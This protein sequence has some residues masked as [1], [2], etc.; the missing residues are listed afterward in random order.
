MRPLLLL[1]VSPVI[2]KVFI[3]DITEN[4]KR[5]NLY[6]TICGLCIVF[7]MGLRS[8]FSGSTDTDSYC[9]LFER[10][11]K[12]G[13]G[14]LDFIERRRS[15]SGLLFSEI[16]YSIYVWL[17]ANIFESSQWL[18]IIT[19]IIMTVC[20][21][22][23]I[24]KHSED[25]VVSLVMFI[26]LGLFTFNMNGMRQCIAMSICL[27]AYDC[28]KNKKFIPFAL[29]ILLAMSFHKSALIFAFAYFV[30]FMKP[31]WNYIIFFFISLVLFIA[32]ADD[33]SFLYDSSY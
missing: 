8:R 5:R 1:A 11:Q 13:I 3:G 17:L 24:S 4:K 22:K 27:L 7:V 26:C 12:T 28:I 29:L 2:I 20:T 15:D 9:S 30:A 21:L 6:L 18:L 19:A 33:I 10:I 14:F 25:V 31:K 32:Y 16:G 23:F